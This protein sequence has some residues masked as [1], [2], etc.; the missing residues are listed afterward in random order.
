MTRS[1]TIIAVL[2]FVVA[3]GIGGT[4]YANP[5]LFAI[6]VTTNSAATTSPAFMLPGKATSTTPVYDSYTQ[7]TSGGQ[8]SK[9]DRAGL[10]MNFT[11][12]STASVFR[13]C[14][15]YSQD[16]IDWFGS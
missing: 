7:T 8:V 15:E 12:S 14:P 4:A 10:L 9:A 1:Q 6:G 11:G 3:L 16:G 13:G 5:S 2:L